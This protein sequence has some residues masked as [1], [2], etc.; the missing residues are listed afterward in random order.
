MSTRTTESKNGTLEPQRARSRC[1][2]DAV[3]E[4]VTATAHV[5]ELGLRHEVFHVEHGAEQLILDSR[6]SNSSSAMEMEMDSHGGL[7]VT[8]RQTEWKKKTTQQLR[9]TDL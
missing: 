8:I 9:G 1:V 2:K 4:R 5:V 3:V 6:C 7:E